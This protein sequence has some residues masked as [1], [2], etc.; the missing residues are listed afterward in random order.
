MLQNRIYL[1]EIV[2]K[3]KSYPGEHKAVVPQAL[4]DREQ[5]ILENNRL[6]RKSGT[7]AQNP[8]GTQ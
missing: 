8:P 2:H 6:H 4:W 7:S 5:A 1:G 3:G